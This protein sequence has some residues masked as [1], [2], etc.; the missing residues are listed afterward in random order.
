MNDFS[1]LYARVE[2]LEH[3]ADLLVEVNEKLRT[4][5]AL[6]VNGLK[7]A[8]VHIAKMEAALRTVASAVATSTDIIADALEE[9]SGER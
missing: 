8:N 1:E 2:T 5:E 6:A 9:V 4:S 7:Y 3:R